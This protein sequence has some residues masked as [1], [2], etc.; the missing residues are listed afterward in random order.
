MGS[1]SRVVV[2]DRTL[3]TLPAEVHAFSRPKGIS[4]RAPMETGA[5]SFFASMRSHVRDRCVAVFGDRCGHGVPAEKNSHLFEAFS[6]VDASTTALRRHGWGGLPSPGNHRAEGGRIWMESTPASAASFMSRS[7]SGSGARSRRRVE[8]RRVGYCTPAGARGRRQCHPI[9]A[10]E[11]IPFAGGCDPTLV[12]SGRPRAP[13][14]TREAD[15]HPF[16]LVLLDCQMADW[17]AFQVGEQI[18]NR[19]GFAGTTVM[20]LLSVG[21]HGDAQGYGVNAGRPVRDD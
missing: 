1:V 3:A 10:I 8:A 14:G 12:D 7:L 5:R 2:V 21:Q 11:E 13:H 17:T 15:G 16:A 20:M 19:A 9:A 6:Q 4:T 18:K